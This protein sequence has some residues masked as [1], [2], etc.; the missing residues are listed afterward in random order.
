MAEHGAA[1]E[2]AKEA[3]ADGVEAVLTSAIMVCGRGERR[4]G[5]GCG[6]ALVPDLAIAGR[7]IEDE[8]PRPEE[9]SLARSNCGGL[10]E[11]AGV[12][13][14]VDASG[15]V[16]DAAETRGNRMKTGFASERAGEKSRNGLK[17]DCD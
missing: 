13:R 4:K 14:V 11:V 10:T 2:I 8:S 9:R 16:V 17:T 3:G 6:R 1:A 15:V 7:G 5:S 12:G